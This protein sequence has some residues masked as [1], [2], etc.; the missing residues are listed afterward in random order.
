MKEV[1]CYTCGKMVN[2]VRRVVIRGDY[3]RSL[4][5][6]VIYNCEDCYKIKLE[7]DNEIKKI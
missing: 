7:N 4:S 5:R 3:D 6:K 2:E 1:K